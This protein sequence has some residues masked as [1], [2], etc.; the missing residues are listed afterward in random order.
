[1]LKR[2]ISV[3]LSVLIAF[4]SFSVSVNA[5]DLE[6]P[7]GDVIDVEEYETISDY[8]IN[9]GCCNGKASITVLLSGRSGTQFQNG[10]LKLYKYESG[11]WTTVRTWR[12]LSSS[13]NTFSFSD[14][15]VAV[16]SGAKYKVKIT[17]TAY[18]SSTSENIVLSTIK[19]L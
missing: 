16:Q 3:V 10:T 19:T 7:E 2:V 9:L 17:I 18:T 8:S 15:S 1:M 4:C 11:T 5:L 6:E 13:T 14:N 12:N